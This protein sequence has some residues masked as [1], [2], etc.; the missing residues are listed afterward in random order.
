MPDDI[1]AMGNGAEQCRGCK[2]G[3]HNQRKTCRFA[4]R[5]QMIEI[6]HIARGIEQC[7]DKNTTCL[8]RDSPRDTFHIVG[9]NEFD[10]DPELALEALEQANGSTKHMLGRNHLIARATQRCEDHQQCRLT[11]CAG[12][13]ACATLQSGNAPLKRRNRWV[14]AAAIGIAHTVKRKKV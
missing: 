8:G 2:R 9:I 5:C 3:I 7:L 10:R 6:N 1:R 14:A 4:E 11:R 12:Y 13:G